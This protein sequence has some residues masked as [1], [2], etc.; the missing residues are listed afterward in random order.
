MGSEASGEKVC[1]SP[2]TGYP[3]ANAQTEDTEGAKCEA[4]MALVGAK[5]FFELVSWL[6]KSPMAATLGTALLR[7]AVLRNDA[8]AAEL[9]HPI[10]GDLGSSVW[11]FH[12]LRHSNMSSWSNA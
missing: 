7:E 3:Q 4:F 8:C 5:S 6:V 12:W 2:L 1:L 10:A 11:H 9:A